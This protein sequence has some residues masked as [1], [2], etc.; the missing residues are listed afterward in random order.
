MV[1]FSSHSKRLQPFDKIQFISVKT[2]LDSK[3]KIDDV[4]VSNK[5]HIILLVLSSVVTRISK[6]PVENVT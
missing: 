2:M 6:F 4:L 5:R 1:P 3:D